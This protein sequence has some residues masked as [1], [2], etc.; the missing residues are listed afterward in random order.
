V[1]ASEH[2]KINLTEKSGQDSYTPE[3]DGANYSFF[4]LGPGEY[5]ISVYTEQ[6]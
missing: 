6:P 2:Q 5:T 4:E 1:P 3:R